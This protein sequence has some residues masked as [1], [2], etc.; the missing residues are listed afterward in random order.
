MEGNRIN[1]HENNEKL[2]PRKKC[3]KPRHLLKKQRQPSQA[4]I[5]PTRV[6]REKIKEP[7][8]FWGWEGPHMHRNCPLEKRNEGQVPSTQEVETVG[9]ES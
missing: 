8:K 4:T 2:N 6:M 1:S 3:F 9:Q 5:Q 7:L